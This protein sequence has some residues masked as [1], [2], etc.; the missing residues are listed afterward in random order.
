MFYSRSFSAERYHY[1]V[2]NHHRV[3]KTFLL[4]EVNLSIAFAHT[5]T[6]DERSGINDLLTMVVAE[7]EDEEQYVSNQLMN[8]LIRNELI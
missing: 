1:T 7:K 2:G 5:D 6:I 3:Q 8:S 4:F